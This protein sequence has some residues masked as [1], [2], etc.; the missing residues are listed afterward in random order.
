MRNDMNIKIKRLLARNPI[1]LPNDV[2]RCHDEKCQEANQC[3]RFLQKDRGGVRVS[4]AAS[5]R[6]NKGKCTH[7]IQVIENNSI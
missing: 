5:F 1:N 6:D 3:R 4:H 2:C 7:K